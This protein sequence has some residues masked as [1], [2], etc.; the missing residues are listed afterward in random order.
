MILIK[1]KPPETFDE[2]MRIR[3]EACQLFTRALVETSQVELSYL[4]ECIKHRL[5][6]LPLIRHHFD[7]EIQREMNRCRPIGLDMATFNISI[8]PEALKR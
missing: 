1:P 5:D 3:D 8:L 7:A 4:I 2:A 6:L